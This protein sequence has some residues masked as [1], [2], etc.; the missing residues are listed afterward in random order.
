[1]H[2]FWNKVILICPKWIAPNL[3]TF[4]GFLFTLV[5]LALLSLYDYEFYANAPN[6][7]EV[8]PIP[9]WVFL[10]S[11]IFLFLA[12]TLDGIDGKQARR[13]GTSGPLGELFD[14]GLDSLTA[15]IIPLAWFSIFGRSEEHSINALRMFFVVWNVL[16]HFYLT[17]WEKYNTGLLFLPWG[18]DFSMWCTIITFFAAGVRGNDLFNFKLAGLSA[19][20]CFEI[21]LY[22]S[23]GLANLPMIGWN[24]YQSYKNQTG[25]NRTFAE[26]VRPLVSITVFFVMTTLWVLLAPYVLEKDPRVVFIIIGTVFS[27]ICCRLIVA[28]MSNTRA[29]LYNWLL[30]PSGVSIAVC[31]LVDSEV[32]QLTTAYVWCAIALI[33]HIHYGTF[34]VQ[35]MCRHF[36]IMCFKIPTQEPPHA[37]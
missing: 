14:H 8:L 16:I 23:S 2:P 36:R 6:H 32:V 10:A 22:V 25:Y 21:L 31:L 37:D 1:M 24:M 19:G 18:Y 5:M 13:T 9:S 34:V 35:E 3:L 11:S 12:Y 7:P 15:A 28:Q 26:A 27:N 33:T 30:T 4:T 29:D 20:V 17:H